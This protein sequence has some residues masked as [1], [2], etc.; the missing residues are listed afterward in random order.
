MLRIVEHRARVAAFHDAALPHDDDAVADIVGGGEVVGDVDDREAVAVAQVAQQ[1]DDRGAQRGVD[2]RHR[3]VGH[4]QC[5][6]GDQGARDGHPLE[7]A[8]REL[9]REAAADLGQREADAA[10]RLVGCRRDRGLAHDAGHAPRRREQVAVDPLHRVEGLERVLEDR[11]D[12]LHE[13]QPPRACRG[14]SRG[15]CPGSGSRRRSAPPCRGS[16]GPAWSCRCPI[17]PRR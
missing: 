3:L 7:L 12:L 4:Q 17:R 8:A 15:R 11:L 14:R 6:P 1:V 2:H 5:R 9:V 10:Q 16:C 13:G